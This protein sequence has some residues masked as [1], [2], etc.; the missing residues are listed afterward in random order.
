M[1]T[2]IQ[3]KIKLLKLKQKIFNYMDTIYSVCS[4]GK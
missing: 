1:V 3:K 4:T 2:I